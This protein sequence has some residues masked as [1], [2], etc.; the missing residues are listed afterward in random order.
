MFTKLILGLCVPKFGD[1]FLEGLLGCR[2]LVLLA[3]EFV[4]RKLQL[5][6]LKLL[7][8]GEKNGDSNGLILGNGLLG[9]ER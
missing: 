4:K 1:F 9:K 6:L 8:H 5:S 2:L 7:V 3:F